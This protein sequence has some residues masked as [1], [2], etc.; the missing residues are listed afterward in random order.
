MSIPETAQSPVR[1]SR[2]RTLTTQIPISID[3]VGCPE[4]PTTTM[5][6]GYKAKIVQSM[7]REYCTTHICELSFNPSARI[8]NLCLLGFVTGMAKQVIPWGTLVKDP[9]SWI[10]EECFPTGFEWNNPSKIQVGEIFRLLDHWRDRQDKS[11]DPLIWVPTCPLFQGAEDPATRGQTLQKT[12][13]QQ[14][15]DSDE[16]VF[17]LPS[18]EDSDWDKDESND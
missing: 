2:S 3:E 17:I 12:R 8:S 16:E 11:L 6:D 9:S 4:I 1:K 18:S 13:V 5:T 7:L 10:S 15:P 14:L